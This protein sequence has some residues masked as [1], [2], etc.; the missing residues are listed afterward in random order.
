MNQGG[1]Q[2]QSM[3][4]GGYAPAGN[5]APLP[6]QA[7]AFQQARSGPVPTNTPLPCLMC[8]LATHS[9]SLCSAADSYKPR[10]RLDQG[11]WVWQN[12]NPIAPSPK[13]GTQLTSVR[14]ATSVTS[15]LQ[16]ITLDDPLDRSPPSV[17]RFYSASEV[18]VSARQQH[19][20]KNLEVGRFD[21][22]D[23]EDSSEEESE[24]ESESGSEESDLTDESDTSE[25]SDEDS[26]EEEE[27]DSESE[28]SSSPEPK[29]MTARVNSAVGSASLDQPDASCLSFGDKTY[30]VGRGK[31]ED[32][33]YGWQAS[34]ENMTT[35]V[36]ER[37][38]RL[39]EQEREL[40]RR[41][42]AHEEEM[43]ERRRTLHE[44][45]VHAVTRAS[46]QA[47]P[48]PY[49]LPDPAKAASRAVPAAAEKRRIAERVEGAKGK[50]R[51]AEP[52]AQEGGERVDAEMI[53]PALVKEK[54]TTRRV[55]T[56]AY[57]QEGLFEEAKAA[58]ENATVAFKMKTVLAFCPELAAHA[59]ERTKTYYHE[60]PIKPK[61][62]TARVSVFLRD[63][64]GDAQVAHVVS[65]NELTRKKPVFW[66]A[67]EAGLPDPP[68]RL[69]LDRLD[70]V[71]GEY[72]VRA[73][74]DSGSEINVI[75]LSMCSRLGL[76][77]NPLPELKMFTANGQSEDMAGTV[78]NVVIDAGGLKSK[79]HFYVS[80]SECP[81][82]V[83]L[84]QPW[85]RH[86]KAGI[87]W[88]ESGRRWVSW[89]D[90]RG[91][92]RKY[93]DFTHL[94]DG[95]VLRLEDLAGT[96]AE[97]NATVCT[98]ALGRT[99]PPSYHPRPCSHL[100]WDG[101]PCDE[102]RQQPCTRQVVMEE[103]GEVEER[104]RKRVEEK[105]EA[106]RVSLPFCGEDLGETGRPERGM[107]K[108]LAGELERRGGNRVGLEGR[109]LSR[110][111]RKN[112]PQQRD[113][114]TMTGLTNENVAR[115][116]RSSRLMDVPRNAERVDDCTRP[117][118]ENLGRAFAFTSGTES[119]PRVGLFLFR[120]GDVEVSVGGQV[121]DPAQ[122]DRGSN[123]NL[124]DQETYL[125]L[126]SRTRGLQRGVRHNL[127]DGRLERMVEVR[128]EVDGRL[129]RAL[130]VTS[131]HVKERVVLGHD[132]RHEITHL[133]SPPRKVNLLDLAEQE[134]PRPKLRTEDW[135]A[136]VEDLS[137]AHPI[138]ELTERVQ[139][140]A[141]EVGDKGELVSLGK[142][143]ESDKYRSGLSKRARTHLPSQ[144]GQVH[145][146]LQSPDPGEEMC[147]KMTEKDRQ[148]YYGQQGVEEG[149][150][151]TTGPPQEG[152][153]VGE[154][155]VS[156]FLSA[157]RM[158]GESF[159]ARLDAATAT[160]TTIGGWKEAVEEGDEVWEVEVSPEGENEEGEEEL[161][162]LNPVAGL[163][164]TLYKTVD[165][166]IRPVDTDLPAGTRPRMI[167]PA[168]LLDD[169]PD[170]PTHPGP[171]RF[172]ARLTEERLKEL[173]ELVDPT[174]TEE[175]KRLC[176]HVLYENENALAW[177][178]TEKGRFDE[179]LIPPYVNPTIP[180]TPWQHRPISIPAKALPAVLDLLRDKIKAG[181]YERSQA[182]Y[183][184]R[185]FL[186]QKK[187]GAYRIVHDLQPMNAVTIRDAG[188]PPTIE[189][190]V[191]DFGG[192][193]CLGMLDLMDGYG[194]KGLDE[195]SRDMTTFQSP[196]GPLRLRS[197]PQGGTNSVAEFQRTVTFILE[198]ELPD[199][200]DIFVDDVG[201]KGPRTKYE[202]ADGQ[203]E[204]TKEN[205][206]VRRYVREH[207]VN[208][209]RV[210]HKMKRYGGTF[211]GKKLM[212]CAS[213]ADVVGFRCSYEGRRVSERA[214]EKLEAWPTPRSR[215]DV[216]GFMGT[217]SQSR[218]WVKDFGLIT[219]PLR[220]LTR[221]D[222]EFH[223]G[224]AEEA[225]KRELT[226]SILE[227]GFLI[228][229]DY[230]SNKPIVLTVDTSND[231]VGYSLGQD[232]A[233][234]HRRVSRWGTIL[235]N[236]REARYGQ[237]KLE[238]YGLFRALKKTHLYLYGRPF[239]VELD[240]SHVGPMLQ[241]PELAN[242]AMTRW[243]WAIR[244]YTFEVVHVPAAKHVAMDGLSRRKPA[245]DERPDLKD[246]EER[247]DAEVRMARGGEEDEGLNHTKGG[248]DRR[249]EQGLYCGVDD[250]KWTRIG[251]YLQDQRVPDHWT[252]E[253]QRALHRQA[254]GYLLHQGRLYK[255]VE[256]G[257]P[258]EVVVGEERREAIQRQAHDEMGH[259]G[260]RATYNLIAPRFFWPGLYEDVA[261]RVR[262]CKECKHRDL[263]R[264]QPAIGPTV[265]TA[266][267]SKVSLDLVP[268]P[269][270]SRH[271]YLILVQDDLTGWV[272]AR[273]L[274]KGTAASVAEFLWKGLVTR[275]VTPGQITSDLGPGFM[276]EVEEELTKYG[277]PPIR[278]VERLPEADDASERR[279]LLLREALL[280]ACR[281]RTSEWPEKVSLAAWADRVTVR[282]ETG[283]SPYRLVMGRDPVLPLDWVEA[284][285]LVRGWE[286]VA[287]TEELLA[288]R[289]R[290][291]EKREGDVQLALTR[292]RV[293]QTRPVNDDYK[294]L[295][296]LP[297]QRFAR[298]TR[299]GDLVL[300]CN[301][302]L[303][304]QFKHEE[305]DT[306]LGP[307][308]VVGRTASGSYE[309]E[310]VDG[311]AIKVPV[312][313]DR[314]QP[315]YTR[316]DLDVELRDFEEKRP[317]PA[318]RDDD[319]PMADG[320]NELD[321]GE[322]EEEETGRLRNRTA[323]EPDGRTRR[324]SKD[325]GREGGGEEAEEME[326]E[327]EEEDEQFVPEAILGHRHTRQGTLYLVTWEGFRSDADTWE[328]SAE[329]EGMDVL[330]RYLRSHPDGR[331]RVP[332]RGTSR[333]TG[334][335][336]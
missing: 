136:G 137:P 83:L 59:N 126:L 196:L 184:S 100:A 305:E 273:A 20:A 36:R 75:S 167:R 323:K 25:E 312:L 180:H 127:L 289:I 239:V 230:T 225:A 325:L 274:R 324:A 23:D 123:L 245:E 317:A 95:R 73:L 99:D 185:F 302:A 172:G 8:G 71:I 43:E 69:G 61:K 91:S 330:R 79:A 226:R 76:I 310:E 206:Q 26:P 164:C 21:D 119:R 27:S 227:S 256:E 186:V 181:V 33:A 213:E 106:E 254:R 179:T 78:E 89:T 110:K 247:L 263:E 171:Y 104:L 34:R 151:A 157:T 41:A 266:I 153:T 255:K 161:D 209:N 326:V 295:W 236:E 134:T 54:K 205:P 219:A 309:L 176:A 24:A 329:F 50:G 101:Y 132:L 72:C 103:L 169:L 7:V 282:G 87:N 313:P 170:V 31:E 207:L 39:I 174:C 223:W 152:L 279:S 275:G 248:T 262:K 195:R 294:R 82:G 215:T 12:G 335:K 210:L 53:G 68:V 66:P 131:P 105:R 290:Q 107:A 49:R 51:A 202:Q 116:S 293:S 327:E 139:R 261:E 138:V 140:W 251:E 112:Q 320:D 260:T 40:S 192:R 257:R 328:P 270:T 322:E 321:Q 144:T 252:R 242:A 165:K 188:L 118:S 142:R 148:A 336:G 77:H 117:L 121:V 93:G 67:P 182:A 13:D 30:A 212:I 175:E 155:S 38:E 199:P 208:M 308:R 253:E 85:L 287:A 88:D 149:E 222:V 147:W 286:D 128:M 37:E 9:T 81:F 122:P 250:D 18:P 163:C 299:S 44:A 17:T 47:L 125:E 55:K 218:A 90:G 130:F 300:V 265:S 62:T 173:L 86:V 3:P 283:Y 4:Q 19:D 303:G 237:E 318:L 63:E 284:T 57:Q 224:D 271:R 187:S 204:L 198:D 60:V 211:S 141:D 244:L 276:R 156:S 311:S 201:V 109:D 214:L 297:T 193:A 332:R 56:T 28:R 113:Q 35:S 162:E 249:F 94:E 114:D 159:L 241:S 228:T 46:R 190:F 2:S 80:P 16:T 64:G 233:D 160:T 314:I 70:V 98:S 29:R 298:P 5:R 158:T 246:A 194:Q 240:A 183:R 177:D 111:E 319:E 259:K 133:Y 231:A 334:K 200:V 232:D 267:F 120:G 189:S 238:L 135:V 280:R 45:E 258:R 178:D 292:I 96:H 84:G 65:N 264:A 6:P 22:A 14:D 229:L 42:Q 166:K 333:L 272:E 15:M 129:W 124:M 269:P 11:R 306:Y 243:L 52:N 304:T 301:P 145:A 278:S 288:L 307:Y 150:L 234:G 58:L 143:V 92:N 220:R 97:V 235:F 285:F 331:A 146:Y 203:P 191:E 168:D 291:L 316:A 296:E 1:S 216:R 108:Y 32:F 268:M 277:V 48:G 10:I 281:G 221:K 74:L 154:A 102:G 217:V 115:E 315:Y 197:V